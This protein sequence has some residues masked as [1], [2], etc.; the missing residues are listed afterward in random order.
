MKFGKGEEIKKKGGGQ[1]YRERGRG[2]NRGR[3]SR[4][5]GKEGGEKEKGVRCTLKGLKK[6]LNKPV[7]VCSISSHSLSLVSK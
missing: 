3:E 2:M 7:I 6:Q 5:E 1:R 4:W